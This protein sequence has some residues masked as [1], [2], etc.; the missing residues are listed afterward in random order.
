MINTA[1]W[2]M[3]SLDKYI[4]IELNSLK[5]KKD[6]QTNETNFHFSLGVLKIYVLH[7]PK[8]NQKIHQYI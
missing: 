4:L 3:E 6:N 2:E 8:E 7:V 1:P 5:M